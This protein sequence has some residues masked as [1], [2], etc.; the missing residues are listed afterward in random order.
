[1]VEKDQLEVTYVK[2]E[3]NVDQ[4]IMEYNVREQFI[5]ML[6]LFMGQDKK[7]RVQ[8]NT[9]EAQEWTE[10]SLLPEDS[11]FNYSFQL[12]TREFRTHKKVILYCKIVSEITINNVKYSPPVKKII[13]QIIYG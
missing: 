2:V 11:K 9:D 10:F 6:V 5:K 13:F 7:L 4:G 8:C 12:T 1:M 3:F